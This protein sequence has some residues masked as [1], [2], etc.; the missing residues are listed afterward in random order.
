MGSPEEAAR[1]LL[2]IAHTAKRPA[3]RIAAWREL[4]DRGWGK[5][6]AF[7]SMEADDPLELYVIAA[8]IQGIA[9]ELRGRRDAREAS[10]GEASQAAVG[11]N[12]VAVA[13]GRTGAAVGARRPPA[14]GRV[15]R[16]RGRDRRPGDARRPETRPRRRARAGP[17]ALIALT[18]ARP[19][20]GGRRLWRRATAS[21]AAWPADASGMGFVRLAERCREVATTDKGAAAA[22][23]QRPRHQGRRLTSRHPSGSESST[24]RISASSASSSRS[25]SRSSA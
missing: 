4:L 7:A 5:A 11:L 22:W 8:E 14:G 13:C 21:A 2:E 25:A 3:D 6:P 10:A 9:D 12:R 18:C 20:C 19:P 15:Q 17:P 1:G 16:H 23:S 24:A